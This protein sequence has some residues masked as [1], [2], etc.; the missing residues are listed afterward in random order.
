MGVNDIAFPNL[1]IYLENVP[2]NIT[3]FGF[4]IAF[5]GMIIGLGVL[6]GLL[7]AVEIAKRTGQNPE[8]YWDF[9]T[10]AIIFSLL[11]ARI[12]YVVFSWEYYKDNVDQIMNIRGGG[13][14]IYGAVIG[15]LATMY[16]YVRI[17]KI[18]YLTM[19]D[20][21]IPGLVIGQA[22]GR[23]GNFMNREAFGGYTDGL[24]AMRLP[25][26]AV[27]MSDLTSDIMAHV[28]DGVDYIQVHPTFFYESMWNV[29]LLV[30]M[31][32]YHKHKKFQGEILVIYLGGYGLGRGI[33]EGLRTDQLL[34]A[35]TSIAIS[36]LLGIVLFVVAIAIELYIRK[37]MTK[38]AKRKEI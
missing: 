8:Y 20:T 38:I 33:I 18:S 13:M 10:Y 7:L 3:I 30:F 36:Q 12:Y 34:I 21:A 27:R 32:L 24:F 15:A 19:A 22:I 35:G 16:V 4:S 11:G 5:Y 26:E 31:L 37:R 29:G 1:G 6:A 28:T 23:Y 17:K 14:A 2:K 25:L 9:V